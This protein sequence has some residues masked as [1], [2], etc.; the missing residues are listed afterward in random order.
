MAK[1]TVKYNLTEKRKNKE[2]EMSKPAIRNAIYD[3]NP[4]ST[5]SVYFR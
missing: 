5:L 3:V 2:Q 4:S 1:P